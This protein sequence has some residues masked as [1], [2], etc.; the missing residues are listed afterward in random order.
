MKMANKVTWWK[1]LIGMQ[2]AE[3][4]PIV[5]GDLVLVPSS[6]TELR[7]ETA[8]PGSRSLEPLLCLVPPPVDPDLVN[9]PDPDS[10]RDYGPSPV[11][12][13]SLTFEAKEAF[14][15][16]TLA[17]E[18]HATH[19]LF[20]R[21]MHYVRTPKGRVTYLSSSDA[22]PYGV[23]LMPGWSLRSRVETDA[24]KIL[25]GAQALAAKLAKHP[26]GFSAPDISLQALEKQLR[27]VAGIADIVPRSAQ[28]V[29]VHPNGN[30]WDGREVWELLHR[31]GLKWGDMDC[32]QWVDPTHQTDYLIWAEVDD[33]D[34]GYALPERIAAGSQ[35]FHTIRFSFEIARSP[36]PTHVLGQLE[37]LALACQHL[38]GCKLIACLDGEA[39]PSVEQLRGGVLEVEKAFAT[40]GLKTGSHSVCC[41]I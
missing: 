35:H 3:E 17:D 7:A 13:W 33:G 40:L 15:C 11:A 27:R 39:V 24:A 31:L 16:S 23:A 28:I 8:L 30:F 37:R 22:P 12:E 1:R 26:S 25:A 4:Q 19:E 10:A 29:A 18:L 36:A 2:I 38:L 34:L 41:L 21:P 20:G 9:S 5:V 6:Q 32:F 14:D